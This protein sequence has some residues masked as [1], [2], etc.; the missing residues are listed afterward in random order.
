MKLSPHRGHNVCPQNFV[1]HL[2]HY[3]TEMSGQNYINDSQEFYLEELL[4][5]S[6]KH[7]I[8]YKKTFCK[9][10]SMQL[11]IQNYVWD[12][13]DAMM[14]AGLSST[15]KIFAKWTFFQILQLM[16]SYMVW[17]EFC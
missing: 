15:V 3:G 1:P 16:G 12:Y 14:H 10:V 9:Y 17:L 6:L 11:T 4:C 2:G 5:K 8:V 7:N 13:Y